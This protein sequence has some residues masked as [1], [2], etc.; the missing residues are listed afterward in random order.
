M[1]GVTSLQNLIFIATSVTALSTIQW[2]LHHHTE[3]RHYG[4]Y[5]LVGTT[6]ADRHCDK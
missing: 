1:H 2:Q 4:D 5:I 3:C 6:E